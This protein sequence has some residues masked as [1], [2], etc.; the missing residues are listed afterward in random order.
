MLHPSSLR[1]LT[2]F[3]CQVSWPSVVE[4]EIGVRCN[5]T[6]TY[7]PNST[8][9]STSSS[10]FMEFGL[11]ERIVAQLSEIAFSGRLS[12]HFYN[13]PLMRRDLEVLVASARAALPLA[14][15]VLYTN[16]DLLTDA[17]Y[18]SLLDA[19]IDFLIVTRHD[20]VPMKPRLHQRVQFPLDLDISGRAGAVV[21][22]TEPLGRACHAPS[23]ML[24]VMVNGDVILCHE[25][26]RREVVIGNL[27]QSTLR[28]IWFGEE[29]ERLRYQLIRG[30][31]REAGTVCAR[32]DHRAYPGPNMTI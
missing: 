20:N 3:S 11:F 22:G 28:N 5:R 12:F 16:G 18:H 30:N 10:S 31:R 29:M 19:G 17:R 26:A 7:C 25:D 23:E 21:G 27:S 13:E 8:I 24:I 2:N 15:L 4:I 9:G 6:C 14:H 1:N 32:C